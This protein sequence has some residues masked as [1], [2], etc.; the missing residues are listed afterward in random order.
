MFDDSVIQRVHFR[1]RK[2]RQ[3]SFE[4]LTVPSK[5]RWGRY[6][7][8]AYGKLLL[9]LV[10]LNYLFFAAFFAPF[11]APFFAAAF[12]AGF[13]AAFFAAFLVAIGCCC[14][15]LSLTSNDH[16]MMC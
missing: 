15:F 7:A 4:A 3:S 6:L 11:F 1:K 16:K 13:F 5:G 9:F 12:F 14:S 8:C 10:R 2:E